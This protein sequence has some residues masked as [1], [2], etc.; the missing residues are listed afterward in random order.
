MEGPARSRDENRIVLNC[1]KCYDAD[2][3]AA[4]VQPLVSAFFILIL[5]YSGREA[6][7]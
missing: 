4:V 2:I 1:E 5:K 3:G 6:Y 7:V